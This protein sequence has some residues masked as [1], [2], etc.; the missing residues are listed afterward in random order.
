MRLLVASLYRVEV[1]VSLFQE[2]MYMVRTT[3][4][5]PH[6]QVSQRLASRPLPCLEHVATLA[7]VLMIGESAMDPVVTSVASI[8]VK[9]PVYAPA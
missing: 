7:Y 4:V 6:K 2:Q 9:S 5:I 1:G 3:A 8:C